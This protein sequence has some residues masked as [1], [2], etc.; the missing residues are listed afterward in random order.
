MR[1][2]IQ[3]ACPMVEALESRQLL[4]TTTG[5]IEGKVLDIPTLMSPP[6]APPLAGWE[7]FIDVN[8][9]GR[10]DRHEP[11]AITDLTGEYMF[12]DLRPGRYRV[13]VSYPAGW[14]PSP[15]ESAA[16]MLVPISPGETAQPINFAVAPVLSGI[17]ATLLMPKLT[18]IAAGLIGQVVLQLQNQ[19]DGVHLLNGKFDITLTAS[20]TS[21]G[22]AVTTLKSTVQSI[23]LAQGRARKI[24]LAFRIPSTLASGE[25]S[26]TASVLP[27]GASSGIEPVVTAPSGPIIVTQRS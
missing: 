4:S 2:R 17:T 5:A 14:G 8:H 7:V 27:K 1:N 11:K 21:T 25:Y 24:R 15:G 12:T 9:N 23:R 22:P 6:L 13:A 16:S 10:P 19:S 18:S 3:H 20:S 26:L